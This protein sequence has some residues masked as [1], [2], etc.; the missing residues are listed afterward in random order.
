MRRT[1]GSLDPKTLEMSTLLSS[2][3]ISMG[4]HREAQ[5]VHE[6]ILRLVTE[7][8]DGDD[9]TLDTMTP[10]RALAQLELLKQSFLRLHGWDKSPEI[11]TELVHELKSM[12]EY[13]GSKALQAVPEPKKWNPKESADEAKGTFQAPREWVF[14]SGEV[15]GEDGVVK[16]GERR[17]GMGLRR[18]T[19]NWGLG[20]VQGFLGG[21]REETNGGAMGGGRCGGASL[22]G[23]GNGNGKVGGGKKNYNFDGDEK[24]GGYGRGEKVEI[25][26]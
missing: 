2:L 7:G 4:H 17:S 1:W 22:N 15:V 25:Y 26:Y 10:E 16:E 13:K 3:Y 20:F 9:R 5:G 14:V 11:Y 23:F 6:N 24:E 19:S 18:A 8:D 12:P 21:Q